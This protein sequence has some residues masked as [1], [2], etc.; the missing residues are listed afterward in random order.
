MRVGVLASG[1]GTLFE[2]VIESGIEVSVLLVDR[3]CRATEI[4]ESHDISVLAMYRTKPFD[5]LAYTE[6]IV[7]ALEPFELDLILL[8]GFETVL[9]TPLI[10]RYAGR[11]LNA[12]PALLPSFPGAHA[13]RDALKAGVKVTGCTLHIVTPQVDEG[14]IIAQEPVRVLDDDTEESLHARIKEVEHQLY[15]QAIKE[16]ISKCQN[17]H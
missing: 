8:L 5:R 15:P 3:P 12:H 4:A 6:S 9:E 11:I 2:S 7:E 10:D 14:P 17:V 16:F 1:Q 13:V